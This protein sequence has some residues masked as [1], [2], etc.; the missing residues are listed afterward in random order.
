[1]TR[2]YVTVKSTIHSSADVHP[3]RVFFWSGATPELLGSDVEKSVYPPL[4]N[5]KLEDCSSDTSDC[6]SLSAEYVTLQSVS[7]RQVSEEGSTL[8]NWTTKGVA[9][10]DQS[11]INRVPKY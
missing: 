6:K 11:N 4:S 1:M 5:F 3:G 2:P 8:L 7:T 10:R 9:Q